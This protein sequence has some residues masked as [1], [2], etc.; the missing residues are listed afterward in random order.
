MGTQETWLVS[1]HSLFGLVAA[2]GVVMT[3]LLAGWGMAA[4]QQIESEVEATLRA[5]LKNVAL[6]L[7]ALFEKVR[8][9]ATRAAVLVADRTPADLEDRLDLLACALDEGFQIVWYDAGNRERSR[10]GHDSGALAALVLPPPAAPLLGHAPL[11]AIAVPAAILA[12]ARARSGDANYLSAPFQQG[13][14]WFAALTQPIRTPADTGDLLVV[15]FPVTPI[16]AWWSR[17]DLPEDSA[18]AVVDHE[19]LWLRRPFLPKEVGRDIA[20]GP[21][22]AAIRAAGGQAGLTTFVP[23]YT[24]RVP[25]YVAWLPLLRDRMYLAA[26][27][28]TTHVW[29][30]W[31][32]HYGWSLVASVTALVVALSILL[33]ASRSVLRGI[34]AKNTALAALTESEC[35]AQALLSAIPDLMFR[36]DRDG[37]FLE[38]KARKSELHGQSLDTLVGRNNHDITPPVFA[39]LVQ[40]HTDAALAGGGMQRFEFQLPVGG[41]DPRDYEARMSAS[42]PAE[43]TA[44]VRDITERKQVEERLRQAA[45][46]FENTRDGVMIVNLDQRILAVN[47]AF[48]EITGYIE[49]EI[50]DQ[51]PHILQ[52]GRHDRAF[53]QLMWASI[54]QTGYWQ[55]ELW[56]RRK[57]GELY[58]QWLTISTVRDEHGEPTH[59][60]GVL[61]DISQLKRAEERLVHLVHYDP[62]TD[63][64]NRLLAQSR[65]AHAVDQAQRHEQRVGVLLLDLDRFKTV[66]DSLGHPAGDALLCA[67]ALR[68]RER[69]REEDTLARL[70]GDEFLVVLEHLPRP[71]E[72]ASVAQNLLDLLTQPFMLP[73]GSEVYVNASIG[74][75]LYPDD[76]SSAADL[77]QYADTA[78]YQAKEQGRNTYR[79]Y[80]EALTRAAHERLDLERRLR[81]ALERDE[82]LLHYQPQLSVIEGRII[83]VEALVRWQPPGQA[84]VSPARFIPLAEETGLIVPLG[85]WVLRTA[86]AQAQAWRLAGWPSLLMAV[87]LSARQI[88]QPDLVGRVRAALADSGLPAEYLELEITES[89]LMEQGEQAETILRAL[90]ETGVRLA[91]DDFGTGYSSLAYLKRFPIDQLKIDQG[92]VRDIPHDPNDMEIAAAIIALAHTLRLEVLAEGVETTEQLAFLRE[93]G[94]KLCQGY[95]FSRPVPP[96][97][98][99]LL[100]AA[101]P[102]V[103]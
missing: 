85:E 97:D 10:G 99:A 30:L 25:R 59:Y 56:N 31:F 78:V 100:L 76:G 16:M 57:N 39:D 68:L 42:G 26:G 91:I 53:Y 45:M 70:G 54:L 81:G 8:V 41:G 90:K 102:V 72:A 6:P 13:G 48:T 15:I 20:K 4:Y 3:L 55:G 7:N 101:P 35:R 18:V 38:Y 28:S 14:N 79:F 36:L 75:S 62:L 103:K 82:F 66:N 96:E 86:C 27:F 60:V 33:L 83:G 94:C 46:V 84:L 29:V 65:L 63:L 89:G 47:R 61:T 58:P 95:L 12:T 87:N 67:I 88:R 73:D 23:T 11:P 80:T 52:S 71:E 17:L 2:I 74:I 32:H 9:T 69:L 22:V 93:H 34:Q 77:I 24:D 51:N 5:G 98:L 43:V 40:R 19:R 49:A 92:F 21:L 50:L 37:V 1:R 44:I 64:P